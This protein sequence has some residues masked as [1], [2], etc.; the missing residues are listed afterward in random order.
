MKFDMSTPC[1]HCPFR[2]NIAG[3]LYKARAAEIAE[4]VLNGG[5]FPCHKTTVD[6]DNDD[7]GDGGLVTN[8]DS[9][10]CAG[11]AIFATKHGTSSQLSRIFERL[12]VGKVAELDLD[13]PVFDSVEQMVEAQEK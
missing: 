13:A 10:E 4:Y 9:Q 2:T 8:S 5:C 11:A 1:Q 12:R 7:G 3:Y 6:D